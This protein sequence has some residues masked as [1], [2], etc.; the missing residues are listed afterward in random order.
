[1]G[2]R[3]AAD[4]MAE[5]EAVEIARVHRSLTNVTPSP[6]GIE[7]IEHLRRLA[8]E[9]ASGIVLNTPPCRERSLALTH[10]E[11]AVMW[12][13]KSIVLEP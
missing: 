11:D 6:G 12:A 10:L 8:R 1:M 5:I 7:R 4:P 2:I 9:L 3:T 13:V